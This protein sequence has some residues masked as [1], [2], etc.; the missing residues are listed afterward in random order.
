QNRAAL[1][2]AM[3]G[4]MMGQQATAGAERMAAGMSQQLMTAASQ[5]MI[6]REPAASG[7]MLLAAAN[8]MHAG[9]TVDLPVPFSVDDPRIKSI[10]DAALLDQVTLKGVMIDTKNDIMVRQAKAAPLRVEIGDSI[11]RIVSERVRKEVREATRPKQM[12][13]MQDAANPEGIPILIAPRFK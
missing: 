6:A 2:E 8:N 4:Q 1:K 7:T 5:P 11:S 10:L 13:A 3:M 9:A 12:S